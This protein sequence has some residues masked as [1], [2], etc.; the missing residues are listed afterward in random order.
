MH[1]AEG[2]TRRHVAQAAVEL[3]SELPRGFAP[4]DLLRGCLIRMRNPAD[5]G[6]GYVLHEVRE[7]EVS[8]STPRLVKL[9]VPSL[10]WRQARRDAPPP[11]ASLNPRLCFLFTSY[12]H[13]GSCRVA[14]P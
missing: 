13:A 7:V 1:G 3:S 10:G 6:E 2:R 5:G 4:D 11:S 14:T 9:R 12:L 8:A